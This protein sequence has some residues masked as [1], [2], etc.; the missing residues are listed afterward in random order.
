[1]SD[2]TVLYEKQGRL[3][4]ITLNRPHTINAFNYE[5]VAAFN[6]AIHRFAG[7]NDA[8]VAIINGAGPRGFSSGADL[9]ALRKDPATGE[10]I[11]LPPLAIC[12]EMVTPK[13]ILAAI[14]GYCIG[15]GLLLALACDMIFATED[16]RFYIPE[17]RIGVNAVDIPL[18]LARKMGYN[19]AFQF[20]MGLE[21]AGA[22]W[23]QQAGLVN[24]VVE[25]EAT[26]AAVNWANQLTAETA[27]LAVRGIKETLWQATH[28][29][30]AAGQAAGQAWRQKI[31]VSAD[32]Q[33]GL[34][35]FR[36][37]RKPEFRG[38]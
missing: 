28:V 24:V 32:W 33:E 10:D 29:D 16:S 36:E 31:M 17:T 22:A 14:H 25:A 9:K 30:S 13:P 3:S 37:K 18:Q 27:P 5:M 11:P 8:W 12:H 6:E 38:A 15:E 34:A 4:L 23:C 7:D 21:P 20:L 2:Q 26:A 1:M 35:A 19:Q